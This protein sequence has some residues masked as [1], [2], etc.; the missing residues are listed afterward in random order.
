MN[1][2][3]QSD[4]VK[5]GLIAV[6]VI[7]L[8]LM[9]ILPLIY[10]IA[11]AFR[12]GFGAFA[13]AVTDKYAL[14]AIGLT[15][16]VTVITVIINTFF[17]VFAAWCITKFRFKGKKIVSTLIDLPLTISPVI[18]GLI[19]VLTFGRQSFLFICTIFIIKI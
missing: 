18:A 14:K 2:K 9:L 13:K 7:F 11:T 19:F 3:K 4:I 15:V 12:E 16:K 17:G 6:T 10:V 8:V 1:S 5:Y